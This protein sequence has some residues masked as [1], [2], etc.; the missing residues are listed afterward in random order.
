[1]KMKA[2]VISGSRNEEHPMGQKAGPE[3]AAALRRRGWIVA[4]VDGSQPQNVIRNIMRLGPDTI[5]VPVAYGAGG[6]EDGQF[7]SVADLL[8]VPCAGP[9]GAAGEISMDKALFQA[10]V[11]G[12]FATDPEVRTPKGCT[13]C[14][15]MS[16][17][18]IKELIT[19][20]PLPLIVKANFSGSSLGLGVVSSYSDALGKVKALLP[21]SIA[22]LCQELIT[23]ATEISVTI[24]D[25]KSGPAVFPMVGFRKD[26][27]VYD[28]EQKFGPTANTRHIIPAPIDPDQA[29]RVKQ[30]CLR[31]HRAIRACG[32][33]R[34]DILLTKHEIIPLEVN[35]IPGLLPTSITPDA[36]KA[37]GVPFEELAEAY[38]LSALLPRVQ[39]P[40]LTPA[41]R[42]KPALNCGPISE[43]NMSVGMR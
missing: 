24:L 17:A 32:L 40:L 42:A 25:R 13:V 7:H 28:Y 11:E 43:L 10:I 1:M 20:Q 8:G 41:L 16:D 30:V 14:A 2:L 34:Y 4:E 33:F 31:I 29:E 18:Y 9:S 38:A 37:A 36:A 21:S 27:I 5:V 39:A 23:P 15:G 12:I 35:S 6:G 3:V 26:G 22:V 19:L